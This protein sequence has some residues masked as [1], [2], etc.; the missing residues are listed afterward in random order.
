MDTFKA[1]FG[2]FAEA[3]MQVLPTSP[4]AAFFAEWASGSG[5]AALRTGIGWLNWVFPA[6]AAVRILEAWLVAVLAYYLYA[7]VMRWLKVI[8]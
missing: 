4:F 8:G 7:I 3:L 5:Y 2:H 6:A 1:L